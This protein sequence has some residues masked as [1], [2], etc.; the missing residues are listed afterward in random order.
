MVLSESDLPV[1]FPSLA[2]TDYAITSDYNED[3]NCIAWAA[4]VDTEWWEPDPFF[5]YFWPLGVPRVYA[6]A[7]Y[8]AAY[9]TVGYE[10]CDEGIL[11]DDFEKIVIY[12]DSLTNR[13]LHAAR[14]LN[15]GKWTSKL[16]KNVDIMHSTPEGLNGQNYGVAT[17]FM[18]RVKSDT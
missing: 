1:I 12:L 4:E 10:T 5:I 8:V 18:K 9:S 3:Y 16:G 6:L 13:P 2:G 7:A 15:D 11:E 17:Q 14:Q